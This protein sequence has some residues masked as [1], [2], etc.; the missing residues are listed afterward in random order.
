MSLLLLTLMWFSVAEANQAPW[1]VRLIIDQSC[2][3]TDGND[4]FDPDGYAL[5]GPAIIA[6]FASEADGLT[7]YQQDN[8]DPFKLTG[9]RSQFKT[10]LGSVTGGSSWSPAMARAVSDIESLPESVRRLLV[11]IYDGGEWI[12]GINPDAER[13]LQSGGDGLVI[14]LGTQVTQA[15]RRP[16]MTQFGDHRAKI[17]PNGDGKAFLG[18]FAD[19]FGYL[20]GS[21]PLVGNAAPGAI[22][23]R[24]DPNVD[25]AWLVVLAR[26]PLQQITS[27]PGNPAGT[28]TPP[29]NSGWTHPETN[30]SYSILEL[31]APAAGTW[32]F[33]AKTGAQAVDYLF[34]QTF[35]YGAMSLSVAP[36][37]ANA[38]CTVTAHFDGTPPPI[39]SAVIA[40][41]E[42]GSP[43]PLTRQQDGS[44]TGKVTFTDPGNKDIRVVAEAGQYR[45]EARQ[46]LKVAKTTHHLQCKG[47]ERTV[48]AGAEFTMTVQQANADYPLEQAW[49]KVDGVQVALEPQG[50]GLYAGSIPIPARLGTVKAEVGSR[51]AGEESVC[52]ETWELR[53]MVD[54]QLNVPAEI[55]V[56]PSELTPWWYPFSGCQP[57]DPA[58]AGQDPNSRCQ[59][60]GDCSGASEFMSTAGTRII[61]SEAIDAIIELTTDLPEGIRVHFVTGEGATELRSGRAE[62]FLLDA[63]A[64]VLPVATCGSNCPEAGVHSLSFAVRVP[65]AFAVSTGAN[66]LG[67]AATIERSVQLTLKVEKSNWW[68]CWAWLIYTIALSTL[69]LYIIRGFYRPLKFKERRS[70]FPQEVRTVTASDFSEEGDAAFMQSFRHA[71]YDEASRVWYPVR[72]GQT[73]WFD[74]AGRMQNHNQGAVVKVELRREETQ[75]RAWFVPL[76]GQPFVCGNKE[77][78]F[79]SDHYDQLCEPGIGLPLKLN[80]I[81]VPLDSN[82]DFDPDSTDP[83]FLFSKS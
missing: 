42:G 4:A 51:F 8:P 38:P 1:D 50:P 72:D 45:D 25:K 18:A 10:R 22:Q 79:T 78:P 64:A 61:P 49:L 37:A 34:L 75:V 57:S 54:L 77:D 32:K 68:T 65:N 59:Q 30:R 5:I 21:T 82:Y 53:P 69:M 58:V 7:V 83:C 28:A 23:V 66:T 2:S 47:D 70:N 46:Q 20:L 26:Q 11:L 44:Y 71:I 35:A 43:T 76:G 15:D 41:P 67:A 48:P 24:V 62:S 9:N 80:H 29:A 56:G 13:L 74:R 14:G 52:T 73:I 36:C 31:D 60:C 27:L 81:Y 17:V 40:H 16:T 3:M 33:M 55:S 6:D 63:N 19:V 39:D 12:S